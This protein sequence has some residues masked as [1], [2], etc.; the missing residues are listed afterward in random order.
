MRKDDDFRKY[1]DLDDDYIGKGGFG[2]VFRA[3]DRTT[4]EPRAIKVIDLREFIKSYINNG[5][6]LSDKELQ[7]TIKSKIN[8]IDI[9]RRMEGENHQNKNTVKVYEYYYIKNKEIAIVMELCDKNLAAL[10]GERFNEPKPKFTFEE[11]RN[12][13]NQLNN[14]FKLLDEF[15]IAHRDLKP[16]NILVKYENDKDKNNYIIKLCDYGEAKRLTVTKKLF[17]TVVLT[18]NY[19]APEILEGNKYGLKCD[20]WSLGIIIYQLYFGKVPYDGSGVIAYMNQI[21]DNGQELLKVTGNEDF[22]DLIRKLLIKDPNKRISWEDYFNHPFL[23]FSQILITLKV[24]N[25]DLNKKEKGQKNY[26]YFLNNQNNENNEIKNLKNE[27]CNLYINGV[28]TEFKFCFEPEKEGIYEIKLVFKKKLTNCS[29]MFCNCDNI[30]K[31]D[32]SSFDSS[33]VKNMNY[34]F[35][36]CHFLEEIN[37]ANLETSNVTD[38]SYLFNKCSTLKKIIFP[39]SFNTNNVANMSLMFHNCFDLTEINFPPSFVTKKV[40]NMESMFS[41]CYRVKKLDLRNFETNEVINMGYM[42]ENCAELKEI[43][44]DPD[45]FKTDN[46]VFM[47]KMFYNC[48]NLGSVN[49][50]KFD[51]SNVKYMDHMFVDCNKLKEID[52]SKLKIS[53]DEINT[54]KIFEDL[55]DVSVKVGKDIINKFKNIFKDVKLITI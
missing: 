45:K 13:L 25:K 41:N 12:I 15:K 14:S 19:A 42:F 37:L 20:L 31:I 46:V 17:S 48:S 11:I 26:I 47:G 55:K 22:D 38:M 32:L 23:N 2:Q 52:L 5:K 1:Y 9:M 50:K 39:D 27:D 21:R 28:K 33:Q 49:I 36:K 29:Y 30:I 44:I 24:Q 34:M 40:K 10:I 7:D 35:G 6:P 4:N 18:E 54:N 53:K 3:T 16:A 43:L 51:Y 8:E